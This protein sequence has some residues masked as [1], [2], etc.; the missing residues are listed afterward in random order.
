MTDRGGH[1]GRRACHCPRQAGLPAGKREHLSSREAAGK[2]AAKGDLGRKP[3]SHEADVLLGDVG[4]D[5][6][7]TE[8]ADAKDFV[9]GRDS[10]AASRAVAAMAALAGE[11]LMKFEAHAAAIPLSL[12]PALLPLAVTPQSLWRDDSKSM[13]ADK[14]GVNVGD[15]IT[16]VV[17]ENTTTTK[18]NKTATSK[19]AAMRP[20]K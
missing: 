8:I 3:Q 11:H 17:Q 7:A 16:I 15:I 2:P 6:D 4:N 18:D 10:N 9:A 1:R 20:R 12:R 14:R 5:P 13:F 19:Q